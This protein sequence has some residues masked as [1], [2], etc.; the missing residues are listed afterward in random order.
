M[1]CHLSPKSLVLFP[2]L[3]TAGAARELRDL[4]IFPLWAAFRVQELKKITSQ[5]S[6]LGVFVFGTLS[7]GF[8]FF[9][10]ILHHISDEFYQ[11]YL[12]DS[13]WI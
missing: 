1:G 12:V 8:V 13:N 10:H 4:L 7:G 9:V 11:S 2:A 6:A 3:S 5:E